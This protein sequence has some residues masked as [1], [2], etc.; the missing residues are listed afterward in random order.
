ML[1]F[2]MLKVNRQVSLTRFLSVTR[3]DVCFALQMLKVPQ[4]N[5][6]IGR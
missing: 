4:Y 1:E 6:A 2:S 3:L 5:A